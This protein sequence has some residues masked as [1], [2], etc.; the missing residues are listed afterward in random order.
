MFVSSSNG[1]GLY[2][3]GNEISSENCTFKS[4]FAIHGG[5]LYI[6][7]WN[8]VNM[9][10]AEFRQN[11][12]SLDGGGINVA[13]DNNLHMLNSEIDG[14]SAGGNGGGIYSHQTNKVH[15][16][17]CDFRNNHAADL[18]GGIVIKGGSTFEFDSEGNANGIYI[19]NNTADYGGGIG[20]AHASM[21]SLRGGTMIHPIPRRRF[22]GSH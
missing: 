6:A 21:W 16:R 12:A 15:I 3:S 11:S 17:L 19:F 18:G 8:K 4:N 14:N 13:L 10:G 22:A 9:T 20:I 5:A 7:R 1:I 2:E